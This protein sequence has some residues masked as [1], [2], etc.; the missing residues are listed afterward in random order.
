MTET[1]SGPL[2]LGRGRREEYYMLSTVVYPP[3]TVQAREAK[4]DVLV[5]A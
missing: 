2:I 3:K 5:A 4:R 1:S